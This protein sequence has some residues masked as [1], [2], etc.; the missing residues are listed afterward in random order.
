MRLTSRLGADGWSD[1]EPLSFSTGEF[2]DHNPATSHDG[3]RLV[4]ASNRPIPGKA[5]TTI[6]GTPIS[7]SDLWMSE[8]TS[9][10]WSVPVPLGPEINTSSDE[11]LPGLTRD[12]T[13]YFGS[14]RPGAP[15]PAAIYRSRFVN[16]RF[17]PPERLPAP[18]TTPAGEMFNCIASD[19]SLVLFLSFAAGTS[20]GLHVSFRQ[21]DGA[22]GVPVKLGEEIT[23]LRA[24]SLTMSPDLRR[25]FFTSAA[26]K[27]APP[28]VYSVDAEVIHNLRPRVSAGQ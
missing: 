12:G 26:N 18:V 14:S 20:G 28:Q 17:A 24:Y 21:P 7:T 16:S 13:L 27:G 3:K 19:E 8:R 22:W 5:P 6:P 1:A 15:G 23:G 25:L 10:G 9:S 11:D 2:F 4:F